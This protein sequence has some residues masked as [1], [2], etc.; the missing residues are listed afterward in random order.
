MDNVRLLLVL[1]LSFLGLHLWSQWQL[2]YGRQAY[3]LP[4]A[5][6]SLSTDPSVATPLDEPPTNLPVPNPE[7][8]T[9]IADVPEQSQSESE[10]ARVISVRSDTLTLAIDLNGGVITNLALPAYPLSSDAPQ[11][12]FAL[13]KR[14]SQRFFF[15]QGGLK[16]EGSSPDHHAR[17]HSDSSEYVLRDGQEQLSVDL[18]WESTEGLTVTKTYTLTRASYVIDIAYRIENASGDDWRFHHYT[19]LQRREDKKKRRLVYTFTGAALSTPSERYEKYD[20]GDLEDEAIDIATKDGWVAVLE[21]YFVA[22]LIPPAS[23]LAHYYSALLDEERYVVGYYG[24]AISVPDRGETVVTTRLFAGPK[25][26]DLLPSIAPGLELTVDY[27]VLWFI[28][29]LI[30]WALDKIHSIV[31]NW[32]WA[33]VLIT[34]AIKAMFYPLSAA[35]YR[36]MAK[37]RRVQPRLLAIRDRYRDDRGRLNQAMME[38]Y[39]EEKINPLGGCFP[40]LIQIPVFIALYWVLLESVELRQAPFMLWI[41]DLSIKDPFFVL[42]LLMGISM[43]LQQKLNPAP[44]DP[45]QA[46]VMQILPF[47]FTIFFAFFPAGLVLYWLVNNV[48]SIAQQWMITRQ[49]EQGGAT[50]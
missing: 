1:A 28:A 29:K 31:G 15:L 17:Y 37:M 14:S 33:I 13:F 23:E 12:P 40:I 43:Y 38:L 27:G 41:K 21:H 16:A 24:P 47:V 39:K 46:K 4:P 48:L 9:V 50:Q 19:Q 11:E 3:D 45:M 18:R 10:A 8:S 42:P 22:A 30:F 6:T 5:D 7:P 25:R 34:V 32:G 26:Q 44:L 35:G 36:S 20:F 2:D 49:I